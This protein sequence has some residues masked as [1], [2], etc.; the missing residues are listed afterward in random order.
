M[1]KAT[2]TAAPDTPKEANAAAAIDTTTGEIITVTED[3]T[4]NK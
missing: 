2:Q 1:S 4:D 3:T